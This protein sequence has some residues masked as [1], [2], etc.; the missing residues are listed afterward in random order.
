M[1][2]RGDDLA[3]WAFGTAQATA[4]RLKTRAQGAPE[5]ASVRELAQRWRKAIERPEWMTGRP[6]P[7]DAQIARFA[8]KTISEGDHPDPLLWKLY[9]PREQFHLVLTAVI[10]SGTHDEDAIAAAVP[11]VLWRWV[12]THFGRWT[13]REWWNESGLL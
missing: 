4:E 6:L 7:L 11:G 5:T 9:K 2:E 3:R 1:Y 8:I 12:N 10:Y 13:L